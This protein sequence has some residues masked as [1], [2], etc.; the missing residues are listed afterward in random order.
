MTKLAEITSKKVLPLSVEGVYIRDL[1]MKQ[2]EEM[3]KDADER[4]ASEDKSFVVEIFQ[5]LVRNL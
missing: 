3:F 4:L 2:F 5:K 1:P